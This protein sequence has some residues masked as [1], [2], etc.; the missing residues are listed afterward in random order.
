MTVFRVPKNKLA[1]VPGL[2]EGRRILRA[3]HG[4]G[5]EE[6]AEEEHLRRQE[7]PHAEFGAEVE[8]RLASSF[9]R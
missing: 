6:P 3:Q 4:I 7:D 9:A 2:G 1:C 8:V 5:E